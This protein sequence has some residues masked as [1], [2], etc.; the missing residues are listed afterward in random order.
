MLVSFCLSASHCNGSSSAPE[1]PVALSLVALI[2]FGLLALF[3]FNVYWTLLSFFPV[4]LD[5]SRWYIGRSLVLPLTL[6]GVA[7]YGFR[8]ALAGLSAL[9]IAGLED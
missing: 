2:R 5:L 6:I 7:V 8:A 1:I 4:T 9:N 3:V